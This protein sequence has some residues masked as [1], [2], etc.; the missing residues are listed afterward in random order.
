MV[1]GRRDFL[2]VKASPSNDACNW[3]VW[4]FDE[5]FAERSTE[6]TPKSQDTA[7]RPR[8]SSLLGKVH[9]FAENNQTIPAVPENQRPAL[10]R[11]FGF[12]GGGDVALDTGVGAVR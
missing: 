12:T 9:D 3:L 7:Q 8:V 2:R 6:L 5:P 4:R 11:L 1:E 10:D